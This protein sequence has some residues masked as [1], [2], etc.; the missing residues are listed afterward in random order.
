MWPCERLRVADRGLREGILTTLMVEDGV[1]RPCAAGAGRL[2]ESDMTQKRGG[3][4]AERPRRRPAQLHVRVKTARKRRPSSQ[5]WLERQLN[6]PYVAASKRDGMRSRAAYKLSEI[7]DKDRLLKPGSRVIDLGAAPGGWS[8]IA[9]E[10]VQSIDGKGQVI[11]IDYLGMEAL[12]G[13]ESWISISRRR[14]RRSSSRRC[15]A[16]GA[17]TWCCPTWRRRPSGIRAPTICASWAS[18][19]PPRISPATCCGRAARL[20]PR[21]CRAAPSA[22]C[23]TC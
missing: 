14:G 2:R 22:S 10:R 20:S 9:A 8:Q 1:L 18:P 3:G 15:C 16:T 23:S 5:R 4:S 6:D 11:A 12:A 17:P 19:R 7:D 13:V 21:C